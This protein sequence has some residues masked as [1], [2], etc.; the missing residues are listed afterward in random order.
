[1]LALRVERASSFSGRSLMLNKSNSTNNFATEPCIASLEHRKEHT[2]SSPP[3]NLGFIGGALDSAVGYAHFSSC[4]MDKQWSL[5][6]GVFSLDA[7]MNRDTA[8]TYGVASDRVYDDWREMLTSEKGRLDAVA[9]LTPTPSH[10]EIVTECL[11]QG[12]PVVCEKALATTSAEVRSILETRNATNGFLAVTYNYSG[13]PMVRE[14]QALIHSGVLGK[15]LHFQVEMPQEGFLRIDAKG[16]KPHPQEWRLHDGSIPTIHLD[17]AVHL[18]QLVHYLTGQRPLE[19]VAEQT[20]C[21]WF[22]VIDN[23]SCLCRYSDDIQGQMWFSKSALGHRNGLKLRIYGSTASAEW[24]QA[25]PEELSIGHA[26][27]HR[28]IRDRGTDSEV[29]SLQRYTRFKVGHPAGF[30]EAFANLYTDIAECLRDTR[31]TGTFDSREVFSAEL[32]LEGMD[33]LEAMVESVYSKDWTPVSN[34]QEI[35]S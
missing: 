32:A 12:M 15:I 30:I 2:M 22:N 10:F 27:G 1:M 34:D 21:G 9:V 31:Q 8:A 7:Q 11:K 33:M 5:V 16:N 26:D 25:N 13:Y 4:M 29:A 28:E 20:T 18:H 17:L 14:L 23:V 19:V 3:L 35:S 6:A 24:F